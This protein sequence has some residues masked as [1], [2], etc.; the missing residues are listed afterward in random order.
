MEEVGL[1]ELKGGWKLSGQLPDTVEEEKE[2]RCLRGGRERNGLL[3]LHV[4]S[5]NSINIACSKIG[6]Y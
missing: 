3:L 2:H 6:P 4:I 1:G 5:I